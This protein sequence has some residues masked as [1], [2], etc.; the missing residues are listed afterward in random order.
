MRFSTLPPLVVAIALIFG[1]AAQHSGSALQAAM[2]AV[3]FVMLG[4][5]VTLEIGTEI[6]ERWRKV[7]P[8][9]DDDGSTS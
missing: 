2:G 9:K 3:G 4:S 1:A 7:R 5:W 6:I 8:P